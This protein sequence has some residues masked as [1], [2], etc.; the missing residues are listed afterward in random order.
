[1]CAGSAIKISHNQF[2]GNVAWFGEGGAIYC[3]NC[4]PTIDNN[5]L[6][7]NRAD[8][9]FGGGLACFQA[10][11]NLTSNTLYGNSAAFGGGGVFSH[12]QSSPVIDDSILWEN[13]AIEGAQ[14]WGD[15]TVNYSDVQGGQPGPGNIDADPLFT[16]AAQL[17]FTLQKGSPCVDQGDPGLLISGRDLAGSPRQLDGD[18]SGK[19]TGDMGA[20]EFG[21]VHLEVSGSFTP[22]GTFTVTSTGDQS[23]HLLLFVGTEPGEAR[24]TPY[25]PVF[26]SFASPWLWLPVSWFGQFLTI[27]TWVVGPVPIVMQELAYDRGAIRG[28]TSNAVAVTIQ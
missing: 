14:I 11:P 2:V 26:F 28:N 15:A 24:L 12:D 1:M 20:Y 3:E 17:D 21:N 23:L 7:A 27:P 22:G 4:S 16:D 10:S 5:L 8:T 25:G 6:V 18:L 9:W 19:A 13:T